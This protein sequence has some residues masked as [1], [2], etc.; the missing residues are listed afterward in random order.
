ME[1]CPRWEWNHCPPSVEC[2]PW[3]EIEARVAQ[4]F[5]RKGR[6]GVAMPDLDLFGEQVQ[7]VAVASN[8]GRPRVPLRIM[9]ALLY[10][11]H[12]FNESEEG[13]VAR[14]GFFSCGTCRFRTLWS[15]GQPLVT[16]SAQPIPAWLAVGCVGSGLP[17]PGLCNTSA[18]SAELHQR[19]CPSA[20]GCRARGDRAHRRITGLHSV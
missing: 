19:Q 2:A 6:A 8:A 15:S 11:K 18:L 14:W 13:V 4:V 16:V 5:S 20:S 3:Q 10:L 7:R 17:G 12:A 9:I 1:R